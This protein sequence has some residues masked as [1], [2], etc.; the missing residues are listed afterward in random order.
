MSS[1][2]CTSCE[3]RKP[4]Q[5]WMNGMRDFSVAADADQRQVVGFLHGVGGEQREAGLPHGH[6]VLVVAE[7]GL[8]AWAARERAVT[9]QQVGVSSPAIL[10]IVG[11]ISSRPWLAVNVVRERAGLQRAVD[12]GRRS[13]LG[14]HLHHHGHAAPEVLLAGGRPGVGVLGYGAGRGDR[15]DGDDFVDLVSDVGDRLG[16][17]HHCH[18]ACHCRS[19]SS[20]EIPAAREPLAY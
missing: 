16:A 9:C 17:V 7:D 2:F 8:S 20:C 6:D 10:Y 13:G 19:L 12:G 3:V 1:I 4:S 15:V 18:S 5:K 14:L 11:I